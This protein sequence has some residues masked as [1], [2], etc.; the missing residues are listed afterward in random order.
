MSQQNNK[1]QIVKII[2]EICTEQNISCT[3]FS[4]DWILQLRKNEQIGYIYGYKFNVNSSASA[5]ICD[6]KCATSEILQNAGIPV[7]EHHF[8]MSPSNIQYVGES[9]NWSRLIA[10]LQKHKKIVCKAN[11]GTGGNAVYLVE[12]QFQL[13][14]AAHQIFNHTRA[15]AVSPYYNITKEYRAIILAGE[16]K[17]LYSKNIPFVVGDGK[18]TVHALLL[19]YMSDNNCFIE[20]DAIDNTILSCG[21]EYRIGWKFNLDKGAI[22]QI[23]PDGDKKTKLTELAIKAANSLSV[24]FASVDIIETGDEMRILEVNSG[25][26]MEKF[27]QAAPENYA[28]AKGIYQQAIEMMIEQ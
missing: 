14:E 17:L 5:M 7:V 27:I 2:K 8:Y 1:R 18:S 28:I 4:Y 9:G 10:Y 15:M 25:I 3:P 13:E 20:S 26:M 21:Q 24:T 6:D 22:P 11:E 16:V 19:Q 12:N 23:L